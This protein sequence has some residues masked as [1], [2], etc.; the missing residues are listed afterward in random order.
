MV[1]QNKILT[2]SY[3]TFSCTLEGFDEP[4]GTMQSIAEYFRDLA[5]DDRYFGA[6]PPTPDAEILHQI[7]ERQIQRRVEARVEGDGVIL[8]PDDAPVAAAGA[9]IAAGVLLAQDEDDQKTP[10]S[11]QPEPTQAP[12]SET[13][14][15][16]PAEDVVEEADPVEVSDAASEPVSDTPEVAA[17]TEELATEAPG[18]IEKVAAEVDA[19]NDAPAEVDELLED[20]EATAFFNTRTADDDASEEPVPLTADEATHDV[21]AEDHDDDTDED[22]EGRDEPLLLTPKD[23]VQPTTDEDVDAILSQLNAQED[24]AVYEEDTFNTANLPAEPN[25]DEAPLRPVGR[26]VRVKRLRRDPDIQAKTAAEK[27][28][29]AIDDATILEAT[30]DDLTDAPQDDAVD[31]ARA[32]TDQTEKLMG[33]IDHEVKAE[34]RRDRRE[35]VFDYGAADQSEETLKR[36]LDETKDQMES[37][38]ASR[39]RSAISHM[40]AA[41]Q[42]RLADDD[43]ADASK[44]DVD[45]EAAYRADLNRAVSPKR[46][47]APSTSPERLRLAPLV[48]VS[49]QR[50]DDDPQG[51]STKASV[52]PANATV[53]PRRVSRRPGTKTETVS[54]AD[55][56]QT[57]SADPA[58]DEFAAYVN[59]ADASDMTGLMASAATYATKV[60][61]M[62]QFSRPHVMRLV[63]G[64]NVNGGISREEALRAF[65]RLL[66]QDR[67]R[68]VAPGRFVLVAENDRNRQTA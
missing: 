23:S 46:P 20:T 52:R 59:G 32:D 19:D 15:G 31:E 1:S 37:K 45:E 11:D 48:L 62:E 13:D 8:R 14:Q 21:P 65:G 28:L 53:R 24:T 9:A 22:K 25:E 34:A 54:T 51:D 61:G 58:R 18:P 38:E 63:V 17:E 66:R 35:Q 43:G 36:I 27:D 30:A 47:T 50:V 42:S 55:P 57:V 60:Q 3:G 12:A 33:L 7:A 6:E 56:I 40:K 41:V 29:S 5:A 26:V 44:N 68:K 16:S 4:F 67:I 49:E 64:L 39:R 10:V 2:V